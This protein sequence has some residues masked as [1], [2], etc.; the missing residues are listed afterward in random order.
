MIINFTSEEKEYL[1]VKN[2]QLKVN[3]DT[4]KEIK[5]KL[6][7]ILYVLNRIG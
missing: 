4:P 7:F 3:K 2:G 5:K 1:E 6:E